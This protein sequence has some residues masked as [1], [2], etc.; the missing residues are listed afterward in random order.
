[1]EPIMTPCTKY[2]WM[3]GYTQMIGTVEM[4][5]AEYLMTLLIWA[6]RWA[7]MGSVPVSAVFMLATS[8]ISRRTFCKGYLL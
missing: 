5:M 8:R 1:M 4:T 6:S 3:K 7:A 2:F